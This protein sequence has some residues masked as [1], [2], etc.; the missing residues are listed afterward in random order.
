[1]AIFKVPRITTTQRSTLI[2][3]VGEIVYDTDQN[4]FYGGDNETVG[5]FLI[6][7]STG[8]EIER[9]TL[10]ELNIESKSVILNKVPLDPEKV[11]ITPECGISQVFGIDFTVEGNRIKWGGLGL[12]NFLDT[13]D[14]LIINY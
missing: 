9:V 2:L 4:N 7:Q 1:M 11:K 5:G 3:E 13:S 6:G 8:T 10:T 14:V 12:D